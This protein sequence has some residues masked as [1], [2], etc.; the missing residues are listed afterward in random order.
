M[1]L[2]AQQMPLI[3]VLGDQDHGGGGYV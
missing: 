1:T 2:S 3:T